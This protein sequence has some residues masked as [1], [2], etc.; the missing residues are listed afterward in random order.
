MY[1]WRNCFEYDKADWNVSLIV[2][3]AQDSPNHHEGEKLY[4][5]HIQRHEE[6]IGGILKSSR[7]GLKQVMMV[8]Y[9]ASIDVDCDDDPL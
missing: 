4:Q 2:H 7:S 6:D 3:D 1:K 5:R 8:F 9:K